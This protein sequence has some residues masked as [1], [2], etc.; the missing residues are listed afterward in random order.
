MIAKIIIHANIYHFGIVSIP[1]SAKI[2]RILRIN[3]HIC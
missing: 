2:Y 1:A 3:S